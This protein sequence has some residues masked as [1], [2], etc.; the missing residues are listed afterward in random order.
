MHAEQFD[1]HGLF[2]FGDITTFKNGFWTVYSPWSSKNV[3]NCNGS[4]ILCK[5]GLISHTCKTILVGVAFLVS[6]ILLPSKMAKFPFWTMGYSPWSSKNSMDWNWLK[7][8]MQVGI[9]ITYM[10]NNFGRCGL[11]S[12][13]DIATFINC[14]I[15]LSVHG[16]QKIQLIGIGS[17]NSCNYKL[18]SSARTPIL[19]SMTSLVSEILLPSRTS[20]V[21]K[22]F[23]RSELAQIIQAI[24]N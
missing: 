16:H 21:I 6:E 24:I 3:I 20:M 15:S 12:F 23:N 9:D 18:M 19:V 11:F 8:F 4:K 7:Q 1:G 2:S 5:Y 10:Q 14:K 13:G 17:K 22:K